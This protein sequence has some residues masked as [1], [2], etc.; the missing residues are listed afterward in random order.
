MSLESIVEK[1]N[2]F[3][4]RLVEVT[5]GEPLIQ[6]KTPFLINILLDKGF[7]VL[8]ETNGSIDISGVDIRCARIVD[9]KCPSSGEHKNN[10][11]NN[12]KEFTERDE[13]KFVVADRADYLYARQ[14]CHRLL[15]E[16]RVKNIYFSPVFSS[17]PFEYLASWILEDGL[18]SRLGIQLH[19]IVWPSE[20]KGF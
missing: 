10:N 3:P 9:I 17:L 6:D 20:S 7:D 14:I 2:E 15:N 11:F 5:G 4:C 1:V 16:T 13:V 18:K 12:L 8:L 19:K